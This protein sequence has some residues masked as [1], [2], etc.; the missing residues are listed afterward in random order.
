M[1]DLKF[2]IQI[3][4]YTYKTIFLTNIL[5][6]SNIFKIF[7]IS[8][9]W[10]IDYKLNFLVNGFEFLFINYINLS[11]NIEVNQVI[12]NKQY[13]FYSIKNAIKY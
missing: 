4:I 5:L 12:I 9:E 2:I 7:K 11:L 8:R 6:L 13:L 10:F 3:Y 1:W